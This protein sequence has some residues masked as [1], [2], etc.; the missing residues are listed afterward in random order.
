MKTISWFNNPYSLNE[1]PQQT[2]IIFSF[3]SPKG[4]QCHPW[5]KCRDYLHD[6]VRCTLTKTTCSIY[7]FNYQ[8]EGKGFAPVDTKKMRMLV[9]QQTVL[10]GTGGKAGRTAFNAKM[11]SALKILNHYEKLAKVT[12]STMKQGKSKDTHYWYF[13]GPQFW[14]KSPPLVSM[15][16]FLIRLGDK[17][18]IFKNNADLLKEY[19]RIAK[20][21]NK[22]A[23]NDLKYI[24][25]VGKKLTTVIKKSKEL[26]GVDKFDKDYFA[27]TD[28]NSFHDNGGI[29]SLCTGVYFNNAKKI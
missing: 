28:I 10:K 27:K 5:A 22:G 6:A 23:D 19:S 16:T 8:P 13:E 17:K 26:I 15:Y 7:G 9:S 21:E 12:L 4:V 1:I 11:K 3:V 20:M 25:N 2:G 24:V 14:L 29:H 18:V